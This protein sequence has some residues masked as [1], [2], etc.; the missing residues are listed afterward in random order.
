MLRGRQLRNSLWYERIAKA[1][2]NGDLDWT[3]IKE[4]VVKVNRMYDQTL[5][6]EVRLAI[7]IYESEHVD[8]VI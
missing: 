5:V 2:E 1:I 3:N 7:R 4:W 8:K 6:E